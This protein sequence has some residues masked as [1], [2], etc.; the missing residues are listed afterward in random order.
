MQFEQFNQVLY[1]ASLK[2]A[3]SSSH[4]LNDK[5]GICLLLPKSEKGLLVIFHSHFQEKGK[6]GL[7]LGTLAI[8]RGGW[9][10]LSVC[11][12]WE[13]R[14]PHGEGEGQWELLA[15]YQSAPSPRL[16]TCGPVMQGWQN[17]R[18]VWNE[19]LIS[20][21]VFNPTM[22][23]VPEPFRLRFSYGRY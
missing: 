8:H 10:S 16:E 4:K 17:C 15:P 2:L 12:R 23:L 3:N 18:E 6:C 7:Y 22:A 1:M 5:D 20:A 11:S 14:Q 13:P 9:C 21:P 19:G